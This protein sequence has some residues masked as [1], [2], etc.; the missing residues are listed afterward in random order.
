[1]ALHART[2]AHF[3]GTLDARDLAL[4]GATDNLIAS[5]GALVG[6]AS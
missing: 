4:K 6:P 2:A 5:A 3:K 1:M